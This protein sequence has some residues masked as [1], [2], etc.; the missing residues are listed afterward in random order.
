MQKYKFRE[1][2]VKYKRLFLKEKRVLSEILGIGAQIEHVGSTAVPGLGGKGIV[3]IAITTSHLQ[4]AREKLEKNGYE[5]RKK[6]SEPQR[7]FFRRDYKTP[8]GKLRVHIHLVKPNSRDWL[9]MMVFR[10][11]LKKYATARKE[12]TKIKKEGVIKAKGKGEVYR[13]HKKAFIEKITRKAF[14][15]QLSRN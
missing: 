4:S 12:Y 15:K 5:F 8:A 9:E 7:L 3:D 1:Y 11:Y 6:A 2:T 13:V 14:K 10:D